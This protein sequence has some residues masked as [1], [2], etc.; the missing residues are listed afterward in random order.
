MPEAEPAALTAEN[1]FKSVHM[2]VRIMRMRPGAALPTYQTELSAGMDLAAYLDEP[3]TLAPG[4]RQAIPTG[5]AIALPA[6]FEAQV[7]GR[8]GL[9]HRDGVTLANGVGTIDAD[10]RGEIKVLLVNHGQTAFTVEPGM[11]V[12]QLVVARVERVEWESAEELDD[13]ERGSGG[14]GHT[15]T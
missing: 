12:A 3:V 5:L 11:R 10:Y 13:T 8:S 7:R 6:G 9:A 15:G 4:E 1:A 2:R 14:F